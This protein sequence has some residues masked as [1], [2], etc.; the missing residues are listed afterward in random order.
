VL[1]TFSPIEPGEIITLRFIIFDE[2][3]DQIDS[4][5]IIDNFRWRRDAIDEPVTQ[6]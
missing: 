5:T 3:D 1:T 2:G 4:T 6:Q